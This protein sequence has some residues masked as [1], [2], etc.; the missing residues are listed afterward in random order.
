MRKY[1]TSK[2]LKFP[3]LLSLILHGVILVIFGYMLMDSEQQKIREAV[4][5]DMIK[6]LK[7][8]TPQLP[9]R[10]TQLRQSNIA[11]KK[12]DEPL[13]RAKFDPNTLSS[14]SFR[15][16]QKIDAPDL[17]PLAP[18]L[19]TTAKGFDSRFEMSLPSTGARLFALC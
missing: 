11:I 12:L 1:N 19:G 3:L 10:V 14:P 17:T 2:G 18:N 7:E 6:A 15:I 16:K 5:V 4:A 13:T 8:K 9:R